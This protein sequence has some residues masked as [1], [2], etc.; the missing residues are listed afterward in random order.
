MG[1]STNRIYWIHIQIDLAEM[2]KIISLN[3]EEKD[4]EHKAILEIIIC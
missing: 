3:K 1:N 2:V 4:K